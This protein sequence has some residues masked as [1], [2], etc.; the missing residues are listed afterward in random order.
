VVVTHPDNVLVQ[1][2]AI[3][4][5]VRPGENGAWPSDMEICRLEA[6]VARDLAFDTAP[7]VHDQKVAELD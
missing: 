4:D 1:V 5:R 3:G 7:E 2:L 6:D